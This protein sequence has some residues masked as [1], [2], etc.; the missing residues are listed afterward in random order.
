MGFDLVAHREESIPVEGLA[1]L[2]ANIRNN[3]GVQVMVGR[4]EFGLFP[5]QYR[6][7]PQKTRAADPEPVEGIRGVK[8]GVGGE[9]APK[10]VPSKSAYRRIGTIMPI[11]V[12]NDLFL[13]DLKEYSSAF[14]LWRTPRLGG[15][16]G[17]IIGGTLGCRNR[18]FSG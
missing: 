3:P 12:G 8:D 10:R 14:V 5:E 17:R 6:V 2:P 15:I 16:V 13:D 4:G 7:V 11:H 18:R 9:Q 1:L